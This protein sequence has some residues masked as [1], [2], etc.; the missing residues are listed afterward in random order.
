MTANQLVKM[1]EVTSSVDKTSDGTQRTEEEGNVGTEEGGDVTVEPEE[2][3]G[4]DVTN[5]AEGNVIDMVE[6][7]QHKLNDSVGG[8]IEQSPSRTRKVDL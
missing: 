7:S 4:G 8:E 2:R 3:K 6:S 5:M 1:E